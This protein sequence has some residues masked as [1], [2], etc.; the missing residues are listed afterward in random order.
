MGWPNNRIL[1]G[2]L[3]GLR[4]SLWS[5]D[6]LAVWGRRTAKRFDNTAQGQQSATLGKCVAD[7]PYEL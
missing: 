5:L 6:N 4:R 1:A 2:E 3:T 7:F